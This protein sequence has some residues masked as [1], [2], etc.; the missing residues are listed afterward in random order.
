MRRRELLR[1]A[2][3]GKRSDGG[4]GR[5]VESRRRGAAAGDDADHPPADGK[6]VSGAAIR[7]GGPPARGGF[8]R[9]AVHRQGEGRTAGSPTPSPPARRH[10]H[11]L[12]R[13]ADPASRHG[14]PITL[15]A[16]VHLGCFELFA[17]ER[18]RTLRDLKGKTV[19]VRGLEGPEHVFLSSMLAYV[20]LD[21]RKDITWVTHSTDK[22]IA[23]LAEGKI[24]AFMGFPPI[25]RSC[26]RRRSA[27]WSSTA[28]R[29]ALVAVLLLHRGGEPR[30]RAKHP[31][32][33]KRAL[34]A[35]L[36]AHRRLRARSRSASPRYARRQRLDARATT[37]RCRR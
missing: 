19:G 5:E 28:P 31:V 9:R 35:I 23:L 15:L 2:M 6:H 36:K 32:A 10:Q 11:A 37:T 26:A 33:T 3:A 7:G 17:T 27:T 34:R 14:A 4:A 20:G 16:G 25:P 24:D 21:P 1:G 29:P 12:L 18:V 8:H 30:V 22:S 13:S